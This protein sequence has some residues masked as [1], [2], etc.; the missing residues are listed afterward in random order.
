VTTAAAVHISDFAAATINIIDGAKGKAVLIA[1]ST[2]AVDAPNA[3][4]SPT[5]RDLYAIDVV[6]K[7]ET[8]SQKMRT[9][10]R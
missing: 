7:I 1:A 4:R 9:G 5:N 2:K 8:M 10:P 3:M 6:M